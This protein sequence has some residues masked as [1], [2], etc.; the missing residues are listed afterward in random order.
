[1]VQLRS[2]SA[3]VGFYGDV[4]VIVNDTQEII[5]VSDAYALMSYTSVVAFT[6]GKRIYLLPRYDYS[7]TTWK[8]V[9]AFV[10]DFTNLNDMCAK[11]IR[12]IIKHYDDNAQYVYCDAYRN[13]WGEWR[14][15]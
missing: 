9:H 3:R 11:D 5:D 14:T 4:S 2:M 13:M 12:D 10:Q 15:F 6:D 7:N 8:H 1:M